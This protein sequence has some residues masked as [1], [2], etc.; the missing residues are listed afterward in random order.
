ME[1]LPHVGDGVTKK[2]SGIVNVCSVEEE[3]MGVVTKQ[4][5]CLKKSKS[6]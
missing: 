5:Y 2:E 6:K 4:P 3:K 1:V